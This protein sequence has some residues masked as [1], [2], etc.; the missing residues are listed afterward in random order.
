MYLNIKQNVSKHRSNRLNKSIKLGPKIDQNRSEN[1][2]MSVQKSTKNEATVIVLLRVYTRF[3]CKKGLRSL[4]SL[5]PSITSDFKVDPTH[6]DCRKQF[7]SSIVNYDSY[8]QYYEIIKALYLPEIII[9]FCLLSQDKI[10]SICL[11]MAKS[12]FSKK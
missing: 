10:I 11:N 9:M 6:P 1:R 5:R 2:R 4:R 7:K 3:Q 8:H 12:C